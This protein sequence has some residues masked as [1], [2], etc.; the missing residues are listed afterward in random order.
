MREWLKNN[1]KNLI[2]FKK[3]KHKKIEIKQKKLRKWKIEF[4]HETK[5]KSPNH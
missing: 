5:L 4:E 3:E 1:K 2:E